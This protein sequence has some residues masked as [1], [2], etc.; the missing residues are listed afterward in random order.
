M[1]IKRGAIAVALIDPDIKNEH[2]LLQI[3]ELINR[4]DFDVIFVGGSLISESAFDFRIK[5]IKDNTT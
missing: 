4:S 1:R 2:H 3:V 5:R